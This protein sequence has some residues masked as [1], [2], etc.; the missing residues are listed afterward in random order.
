[1]DGSSSNDHVEN[2]SQGHNLDDIKLQVAS[3]AKTLLAALESDNGSDKFTTV[4][5]R[6]QKPRADNRDTAHNT[7]RERLYSVGGRGSSAMLMPPGDATRSR[8]S[9]VSQPRRPGQAAYAA[10][11]SRQSDAA[12]APQVAIIGTS[13]VR[14]LGP[15][16]TR[17]G[18]SA[19]TFVY[20]GLEIPAI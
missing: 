18:V 1:M 14:G 4:S 5:Y 6:K 2:V 17:W 3:A 11:A 8:P 15:M 10:T 16:L 7:A 9:P 13:L 20:R 19:T 12:R